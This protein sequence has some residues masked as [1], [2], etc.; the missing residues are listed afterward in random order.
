MTLE[1]FFVQLEAQEL[2]FRANQFG[3]LRDQEDLC[4]L[5]SL[6]KRLGLGQW[7][8]EHYWKAAE[9]MGLSNEDAETVAH[10]ADLMDCQYGPTA[11]V[12]KR[13]WAFVEEPQG[14]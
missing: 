6:C 3:E 2:S 12:R 14:A 4:P 9:A 8:S 10:A 1:D 13:L 11:R 7:G 5:C